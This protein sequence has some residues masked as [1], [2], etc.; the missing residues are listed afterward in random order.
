MKKHILPAVLAMALMMLPAAHAETIS[1]S[2]TVQPAEETVAYATAGGTIESV[3][4]TAGQ[5]VSKGDALL[6]LATEKVYATQSGTITGVFAQTGDDADTATEDYG[7]VMYMEGDVRFTL[8]AS[9][10]NAYKSAA[11]KYVH[12][13]ES[14]YLVNTSDSTLTGTGVITAVSGTSYTVEVTEGNF[15]SSEKY[16]IYREESH[17]STSRIGRGTVSRTDPVAVTGSGTIVSMSVKDGDYVEK[18]QLLFETLTG[19]ANGGAAPSATLYAEEDG[20]VEAVNVSAGSTLTK[21]DA[22]ATI[23]KTEKLCM[24]AEINEADLAYLSVGDTVDMTFTWN[25]EATVTGRVSSIAY[26]ATEDASSVTYT[27]H[28]DFVPDETVRLGMTATIDT[29]E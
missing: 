25:E 18:G 15:T 22:V 6:K 2:G 29:K 14:V 12:I 9:T 26:T 3:Y 19:T 1:L 24:E 4:I 23:C 16:D 20:I 11:T 5:K 27:V 7:G 28:I 8:S 10:S 21:G 13:G 17:V